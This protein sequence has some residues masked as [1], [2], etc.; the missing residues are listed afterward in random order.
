MH[1]RIYFIDNCYIQAL[2]INLIAIEMLRATAIYY[3]IYISEF[4]QD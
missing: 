1:V 2:H 3:I 4:I